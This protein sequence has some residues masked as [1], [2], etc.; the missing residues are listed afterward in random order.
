[1]M[2]NFSG[3]ETVTF[4]YLET[5]NL[6]PVQMAKEQQNSPSASVITKNVSLWLYKTGLGRSI[7]ELHKSDIGRENSR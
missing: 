7:L 5:D 6:L 4:V 2:E 3:S 1:M